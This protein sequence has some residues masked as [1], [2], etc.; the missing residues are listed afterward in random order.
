[1]RQTILAFIAL[2]FG[3][4]ILLAQ[5]EA[6]TLDQAKQMAS[7]EKKPILIEFFRPD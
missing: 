5:K 2:I 3:A 6:T 4:N 1:M 7:S